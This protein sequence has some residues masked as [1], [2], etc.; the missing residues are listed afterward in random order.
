MISSPANIGMMKSKEK[1]KAWYIIDGNADKL[2]KLLKDQTTCWEEFE[3]IIKLS[4][5]L[6]LEIKGVGLDLAAGVCW[7]TAL[8]SRIGTVEKIYAVEISKHR[9]LKIAPLVLDLFKAQSDKIVRV[10]GDF[11]NIK[12]E[13]SSVYFCFMSQAFHH[14]DKPGKLLKEVY[15]ILKPGGFILLIGE[16]PIFYKQIIVKYIKN[17]IKIIFPFLK[18]KTKLIKKIFIGFKDLYPPNEESGDHYYRI[19]DY[20]DIF[21][22]YKYS[23]YINKQRRFSTFVAVKPGR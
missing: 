3:D 5:T 9:L 8:L 4:G 10:I 19:K 20:M 22:S 23:F 18:F 11:Y 1:A 13:D 17:T 2:I 15:R 7:T 6:G 21:S 14:A 16:S 12:L